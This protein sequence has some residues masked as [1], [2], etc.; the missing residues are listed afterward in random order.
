MYKK[1][2]LLGGLL[3]LTILFS[4]CGIPQEDYDKVVADKYSA[5]LSANT[6]IRG[7]RAEIATMIKPPKYFENRTAIQNW[8][9]SIPKLGIS[10]DVEQWFQYAIYYQQK[11]MESG[12]YLSVSYGI[13]NKRVTITCDIF[14]IDGYLYYFNPDNC[15]LHD[16]NI[17]ID[18]L[19][20]KYLETKYAGK[21]Q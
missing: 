18:M 7:L 5:E 6:T 13:V 4:S 19:D 15:E 2:L 9:N 21:L 8:L 12:Y 1:L 11:A 3:A 14:T 17:Q 10:K 20:I 16:A